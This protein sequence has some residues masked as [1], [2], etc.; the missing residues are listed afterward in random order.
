MKFELLQTPWFHGY[1]RNLMNE[2]Y[3]IKMKHD[4][5]SWNSDLWEDGEIYHNDYGHKKMLTNTSVMPNSISAFIEYL[6]SDEF[7]T[8]VKDITGI[9]ELYI[10]KN[11]YGGGLFMHPP[12]SSLTKHID[13]NYNSD[14]GMYRAV[15]LLYYLNDDCEG[16]N[17]DMYNTD[18]ELKK[19][20]RPLLNSCILF[21][22]N[23]DTYHGVS[24]VTSGYRKTISLWYYTKEPTKNLSSEPHKTLWVE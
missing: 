3:A 24:K 5:P 10:D 21:L 23:N 22:T 15:N 6:H 20:I 11:L 9:E 19:S 4:F 2:E 7:V 18:L 12:G 14:L 17:F 16:G 1:S 8:K 13:F